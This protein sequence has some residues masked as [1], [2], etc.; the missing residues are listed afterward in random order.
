MCVCFILAAFTLLQTKPFDLKLPVNLLLAR[1]RS[2]FQ[3]ETKKNAHSSFAN[4]VN[5]EQCMTHS[6]GLGIEKRNC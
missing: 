6:C 2:E 4:N 1:L 5:V 3:I